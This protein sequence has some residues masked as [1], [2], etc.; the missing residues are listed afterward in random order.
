MLCIAVLLLLHGNIV[1]SGEIRGRVVGEDGVGIAQAVVFV[2]AL[3]T[4]AAPHTRPRSIIMDQVNNEFVPT[5]LPI[6]VGTKVSFPNHDQIHHHVYSFSRTKNFELPLY[7]SE[8]ALPVH[9][10]H[11]GVVKIG[12]NIHDWMYAIIFVAPTPYFALT[13][14]AGTFLLKDLPPGAYPVTVW[15]E[16]S[17]AKAEDLVQQLQAAEQTPEVVFTLP[18]AKR[19]PRPTT[20]RGTGY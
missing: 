5:L 15:H 12:C 13:N 4:T 14:G 18:L 8:K 20:R 2:S 7:K 10:D 17:Q 16:A 1:H 6:A 11:P 19:P 9:F 3:P